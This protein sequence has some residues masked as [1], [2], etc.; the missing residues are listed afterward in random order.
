MAKYTSKASVFVTNSTS[1]ASLK[2]P[3]RL[4]ST[5]FH[6]PHGCLNTSYNWLQPQWQT[7]RAKQVY[8]YQTL[9]AKGAWFLSKLNK[10]SELISISTKIDEQ[11]KWICTKINELRGWF[12]SVLGNWWFAHIPLL[13]TPSLWLLNAKFDQYPTNLTTQR[14]LNNILITRC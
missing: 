4:K 12:F 6:L 14:Q 1:K 3:C 10:R 11:S 13:H 9:R 2:L 8:L 7:T 5:V